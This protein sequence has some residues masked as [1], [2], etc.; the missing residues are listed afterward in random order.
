MGSKATGKMQY[1]ADE[2]ADAYIYIIHD[3]KKM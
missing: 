3:K 2:D 1:G